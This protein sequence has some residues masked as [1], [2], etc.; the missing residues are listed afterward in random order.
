MKKLTQ[1]K[2]ILLYTL[3]LAFSVSIIY[4]VLRY[5]LR[6]DW[7][8][9]EHVYHKVYNYQ[10]SN[11]Q[12][13]K[14]II[15]SLNMEFIHAKKEMPV[16]DYDWKEEERKIDLMVEGKRILH[17]V[18][19][20]G[21]EIDIPFS[22]SAVSTGAITSSQFLDDSL[23]KKLNLRFPNFIA[24]EEEKYIAFLN[25]LML[26]PG[27]TLYQNERD[28]TKSVISFQLK[29]PKTSELQT[30]Y[31]YNELD[32]SW[33]PIFF[34]QSKES[35]QKEGQEFFD[36]YQNRSRIKFWHR[37][38]PYVNELSNTPDNLRTRIYYSDDI[39]NFPLS[40]STTGSK[41]EMTITDSYIIDQVDYDQYLLRSTSKTYTEK[42]KEEYISDVL[43][44]Y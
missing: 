37:I 13:K 24:S 33:T 21:T 20:D 22:L 2:K 25:L 17:I 1:K 11:L 35:I 31:V 3:L 9:S 14:K 6:P 32:F 36:D 8:D 19:T 44:K 40:V 12:P 10:V 18:F 28:V 43:N 16:G 4:V 27:D 23:Y 34:L 15:K 38:E 30:Y 42:N 5:Y 26:Y 29:N 7:F 41:F 39:R